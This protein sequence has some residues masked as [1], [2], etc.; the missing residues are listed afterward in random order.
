VPGVS[1]K[2][3]GDGWVANLKTLC[4]N[5]RLELSSEDERELEQ[6]MVGKIAPPR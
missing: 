2:E 5:A 4:V 6:W 3:L 1:A